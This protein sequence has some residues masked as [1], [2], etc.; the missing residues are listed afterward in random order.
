MS[1]DKE[2]HSKY[3]HQFQLVTNTTITN[4]SMDE[5]GNEIKTVNTTTTT[6]TLQISVTAKEDG[7]QNWT[8][9]KSTISA[10]SVI[11]MY[12]KVETETK[13]GYGEYGTKISWEKLNLIAYF[14]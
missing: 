5:Q 14:L 10:T 13:M 2:G 6:E 11:E 9:D 8:I 7:G 4:F 3:S 1:D 12:K